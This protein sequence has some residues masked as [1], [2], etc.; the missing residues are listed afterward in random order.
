MQRFKNRTDAGRHLARQLKKYADQDNVIVL[1]LPRGGVP[2]ALPVAKALN[3]PMDV[4]VVRKLGVPRQPEVAMGAI[5]SGGSFVLNQSVIEALGL[6]D[7]DI[8]EVASRE[9]LEL[10]RREEIYRGKRP[11]PDLTDKIVLLV[12]DGLATGSTMRAALMAVWVRNPARVVVA[13]PVGSREACTS[14]ENQA[15]EVVCLETPEPF[16]AVG[17]W[18]EQFSQTSDREVR[19]CLAEAEQHRAAGS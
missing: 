8:S 16:Q 13:A 6:K 5:A 14:L 11:E 18:Y 7:S 1:G 3:A 19:Q 15:D 10:A 17:L 2:V 4:F 9:R 12:D